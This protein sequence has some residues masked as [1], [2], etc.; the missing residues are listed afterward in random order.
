MRA[1][2]RKITPKKLKEAEAAL[3]AARRG[4]LEDE[5][6]G[7]FNAAA[8]SAIFIHLSLTGWNPQK[9]PQRAAGARAAILIA[10]K[11][12]EKKGQA[13]REDRRVPKGANAS[14]PQILAQK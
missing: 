9:T 4:F 14:H 1:K 10:L 8:E 12:L 7:D 13:R 11:N 2:Y 3:A 5:L 6:T